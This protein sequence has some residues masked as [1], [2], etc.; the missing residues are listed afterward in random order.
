MNNINMQGNKTGLNSIV[1]TL[2]AAKLNVIC[3]IMFLIETILLYVEMFEYGIIGF[4]GFERVYAIVDSWGEETTVYFALVSIVGAIFCILPIFIKFSKRQRL[5]IPKIAAIFNVLLIIFMIIFFIYGVQDT[6]SYAETYIEWKLKLSGYFYIVIS[7][8]LVV[9]LFVTT[10]K[11]KNIQTAVPQNI[12]QN[13][14]QQW[15]Q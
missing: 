3:A 4:G 13:V 7:V 9:L 12:P 1:K 8:A 14:P 6:A 2:I 10:K 5:I 15:N 11:Q